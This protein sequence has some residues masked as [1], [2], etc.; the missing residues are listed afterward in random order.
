V[1]VIVENRAGTSGSIGAQAAVTSPLRRATERTFLLVFDAHA[2][3]PSVQPNLLYD[4]LKDLAPVMPI[5]TSPRVITSHPATAY[6]SFADLV[7]AL[8]KNGGAV[9]YGK[10]G[11]GSLAPL[12]M[13][14]IADGLKVTMTRVPY[15]GGGPLLTDAVSGY[16]PVAV[17]S[18][19][20]FSP[21]IS[22]GGSQP[23][24][25]HLDG[26][27]CTFP[28]IPTVRVLL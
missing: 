22:T 21:Q 1:A 20:L 23:T 18:L 25:R 13:S 5:G 27:L 3:N 2:V 28:D 11:T 15:R 10:V 19:A 7:A 14:S 16:V 8:R 12:A 4:T 6:R 24:C 17:A 9:N 26:S